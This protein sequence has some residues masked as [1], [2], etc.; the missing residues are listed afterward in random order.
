MSSVLARESE[1][2]RL[3]TNERI[4]GLDLMRGRKEGPP[5]APED[6]ESVP[7]AVAALPH[8]S[9]PT[10]EQVSVVTG[11]PPTPGSGVDPDSEVDRAPDAH[12]SG[13]PL[14]GRE[15]RQDGPSP[16]KREKP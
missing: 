2:H 16:P 4:L 12:T 13:L 14:F 15:E 7:A 3:L 5:R 1:V 9:D 6:S 11:P 10:E 8:P